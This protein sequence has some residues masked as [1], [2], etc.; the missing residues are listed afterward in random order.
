MSKP[1]GGPAMPNTYYKP[2]SCGLQLAVT[3][4]GGGMSLRDWFSG[5]AIPGVMRI[6]DESLK[7]GL[8]REVHP[9]VWKVSKM[10]YQIADAMLKE[11][12]KLDT[13]E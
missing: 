8:E 5:M 3:G 4:H 13:G 6:I 9:D 12:E 7:D 10:S 1:D 2:C 11:G